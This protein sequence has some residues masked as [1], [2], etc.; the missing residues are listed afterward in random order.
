MLVILEHEIKRLCKAPYI[1]LLLA[2]AQ[3]VFAWSF[4]AR[5]EIWLGKQYEAAIQNSQLGVTDFIIMPLFQIAMVFI[6]LVLPFL[7][8]QS[9]A[10]ERQQQTWALLASSPNALYKIILGKFTALLVFCCL[11]II[12]ILLMML[13]LSWQSPL[14]YGQILSG[15]F[16]FLLCCAAL[17]MLG[18]FI[19]ASANSLITATI[20]TLAVFILLFNINWLSFDGNSVLL[21]YLSF[22]EHLLNAQKGLVSTHDLLFFLLTTIVFYISTFIKLDTQRL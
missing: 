11:P 4:L 6:C 16:F 13:A 1:W 5:L 15:A 14:D 7:T 17:I 22:K 10:G 20:A 2:I 18:L 9:F 19:S 3:F 12:A 21:H 8:A